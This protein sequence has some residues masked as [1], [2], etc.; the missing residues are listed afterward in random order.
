VTYRNPAHVAKCATTLDAITKGRAICGL[1]AAW[2]DVEH[3]GLGFDFPPAPERLARL[4]EAVQICK[5]MFTEQ[6]PSFDGKY[7]SIKNARNV[8]RPIQPGGIPI[9]VG[10]GGEKRTLRTVARYADICNLF[11]D[12]ETLRHKFD[13]LRKHCDDAGRDYE[14]ITRSRLATMIITDD[15]AQTEATEK[16]LAALP[17][18]RASTAFNVGTEKEILSQIDELEAAGVQ[19]FIFN[20]PLSSVEMVRRAGEL[21]HGR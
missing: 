1:G 3:E 4:E 2:F 9:M 20:M 21:L 14:S 13:V 18:T 12:A 17:A 11:G 16:M 19:Y 5:A 10:G 8:P 15:A 6:S 7:Y